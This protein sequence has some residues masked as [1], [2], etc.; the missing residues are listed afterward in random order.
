M[1]ILRITT[2]P[3]N[4]LITPTSDLNKCFS[5]CVFKF[6]F[7]FCSS[8]HPEEGQAF[9]N[10]EQCPLWPSAG[11]QFSSVP[12]LHQRT[13]SRR[14]HAGHEAAT[15]HPAKVLAGGARPAATAQAERATPGATER[16][17]IPDIKAQSKLA[18][19]PLFG[20]SR[21]CG[22]SLTVCCA[23]RSWSLA[24]PSIRERQTDWPRIRCCTM[25]PT[26]TSATLTW[27]APSSFC[28]TPPNR[29]R[30]SC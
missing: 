10:T 23:D 25:T 7:L 3:S 27:R 13:E 14:C 28:R 6:P 29:G 4:Q 8:V 19:L 16:R 20:L 11:V 17:E 21:R 5:P 22:G 15:Q 12:R 2:P 24:V 30:L 1:A 9:G 18:L 26:P